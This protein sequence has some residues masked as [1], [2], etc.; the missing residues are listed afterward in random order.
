[1]YRLSTTKRFE[2]DLTKCL[3]R[4]LPID[5]FK[6]VIDLLVTYGK[7]P[8]HY[9]PH[10]LVGNRSGQWECHIQSDWLLIWEQ[11]DEELTLLL[12][13]TGTHSDLF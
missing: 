2:K 10:K 13:N 9:K 4:G 8:D 11:N 7:I 5:K 1:M 3:R 12:L 6:Q